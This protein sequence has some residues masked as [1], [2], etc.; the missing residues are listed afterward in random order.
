MKKD[1]WTTVRIEPTTSQRDSSLG[2]E[3]LRN[4]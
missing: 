2:L 3:N 1:K 4:V